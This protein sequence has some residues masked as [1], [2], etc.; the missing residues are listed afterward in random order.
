MKEN[1]TVKEENEL[2]GLEISW[3][4]RRFF[5]NGFYFAASEVHLEIQK[6]ASSTT[7]TEIRYT[8]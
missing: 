8:K 3:K 1:D 4:Y 5:Y 6:G 2:C 7:K